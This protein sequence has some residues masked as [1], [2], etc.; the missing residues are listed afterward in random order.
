[1][2]KAN[3]LQA[4][5]LAVLATGVIAGGVYGA[6]AYQQGAV[7]R[8][9]ANMEDVE[10]A[11]TPASQT[12]MT[13]IKSVLSDA[14]VNATRFWLPS[15]GSTENTS[16]IVAAKLLATDDTATKTYTIEKTS[17]KLDAKTNSFTPVQAEATVDKKAYLQYE[18]YQCIQRYAEENNIRDMDCKVLTSGNG[19]IGIAAPASNEILSTFAQVMQDNQDAT[20]DQQF[21][22]MVEAIK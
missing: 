3:R 7:H 8:S 16:I 22:L 9:V 20:L 21:D 2:E 11:P 14:G 5:L 13:Q 17:Y 15:G 18:V 1:M 10:S 12:L 6:N 4:L 19:I